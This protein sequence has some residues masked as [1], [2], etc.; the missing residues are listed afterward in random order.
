MKNLLIR[1]I[2][3]ILFVSVLIIGILYSTYSF[4]ILFAIITGLTI[5]EFSLNVNNHADAHVN[6]IINTIAGISLFIAF[7]SYISGIQDGKIFIPYIVSTT[8]LLIQ[9]LYTKYPDPLKNWAYAFAS[10]LYIA[11]PFSLL[12][13]LAYVYVPEGYNVGWLPLSIFIFLWVSDSGAYCTG[14]LLSRYIPFKL[15]PRISP[16]KSWIGSIGGGLFTIL[17]ACILWHFLPFLSL[18]QWIGLG[19]T[20]CVF[21]TWGD[22][23]ESL[24]KRQLGIKDSGHI[25]PGHGGMLDR[26]DS[27][28]LA[29]PASL[30]YFYTIDMF[31]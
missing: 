19:L 28:L 5:A 7:N 25:L 15:F 4:T 9:E 14:S 22:L 23:V 1:S 16:N 2:T 27:A 26:F 29:I 30:I 8:Y 3:G 21:G 12:S 17:A 31:F 20:V 6:T 11:L 10:Q 18:I 24:F 13:V